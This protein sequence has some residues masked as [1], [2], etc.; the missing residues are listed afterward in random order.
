MTKVPFGAGLVAG[1]SKK[2]AF[3][4]C[5]TT[6]GHRHVRGRLE[7]VITPNCGFR[8]YKPFHKRDSIHFFCG[9]VSPLQHRNRESRRLQSPAA[10]VATDTGNG[11]DAASNVSGNSSTAAH[12]MLKGTPILSATTPQI[13]CPTVRLPKNAI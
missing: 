11:I 2:D 13:V 6:M 12:P 5:I 3:R 9:D 1:I 7:T 4:R 10:E 8:K